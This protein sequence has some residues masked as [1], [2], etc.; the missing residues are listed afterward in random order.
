MAVMYLLGV[1]EDGVTERAFGVPVN[2]RQELSIIQATSAQI[3]LN[4]VNPAGV[5]LPAVGDLVLTIKQKPQDEPALARLEGTWTPMLGAG[6]AIFSWSRTTMAGLPWGRY[7]Y[8]VRLVNGEEV[9]MLI[10]ASPFIL[11]PAV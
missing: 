8:D 3:V 6:K 4:A 2:T 9:N 1:L 10:P 5:A 7:V 11:A